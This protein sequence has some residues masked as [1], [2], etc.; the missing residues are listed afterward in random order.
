VGLKINNIILNTKI[1]TTT[2]I[3]LMMV[4]SIL[5][6]CEQDIEVQHTNLFLW[7]TSTLIELHVK[8]FNE[9]VG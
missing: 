7:V 9:P 6:L 4:V 8:M 5:R 3:N 1:I 2:Y